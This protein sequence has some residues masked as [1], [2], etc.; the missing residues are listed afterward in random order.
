MK[1]ELNELITRVGPATPCGELLRRYWQPVALVDEFNAALDPAMAVRPVK[2]VR[3]LG[4]APTFPLAAT[5]ATAC[6][7]RFTAGSSPPMATAWRPRP[8]RPAA[9]CASASRS[10]A[11]L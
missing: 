7:A 2:A 10:A 1:A 6:A 3:L 9:H 11:T 4:Q 8:S 5:R